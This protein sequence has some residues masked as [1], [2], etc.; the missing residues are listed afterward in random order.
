MQ[1]SRFYRILVVA[2]E[3]SEGRALHTTIRSRA[4]DPGA[5]RVLLVAPA[6][7]SRV[8]HWLSDEAEARRDAEERLRRSLDLLDEAEISAEGVVGDADPLQAID[9]ALRIFPADEI[10]VATHPEGRSNWL[11]RDLIT[12]A[13]RRFTQPI[14]HVVVDDARIAA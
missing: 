7:N 13:R 2:N 12:R 10:V 5:V 14:I 9:D 11:A 6:L 3:T 1:T 8:R 4:P